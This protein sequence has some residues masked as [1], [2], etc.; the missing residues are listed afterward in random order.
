MI[1]AIPRNTPFYKGL[2][3]F[4]FLLL[5]SCASYLDKVNQGKGYIYRFHS[6]TF[7]KAALICFCLG[8]IV[9][10]SI[11]ARSKAFWIYDDKLEL[12]K[13]LRKREQFLLT[14]IEEI[15]WGSSERTVMRAGSGTMARFA[16][17]RKDSMTIFFKDGKE[18]EF[19]ISEYSNFDE[20]RAWFLNYGK[21]KGIIKIAPLAE[22]KRR[23]GKD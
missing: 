11:K 2:A 5:F 17:A 18:I 23:G 9:F 3:V 20:L 7:L 22:R 14:D 21:R 6:E 8:F 4:C 13:F 10:L 12:K 19:W 15:G 1:L 16:S